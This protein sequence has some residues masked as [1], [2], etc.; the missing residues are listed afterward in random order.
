MH[1]RSKIRERLVDVLNTTAIAVTGPVEASRR[2]PLPR[3]FTRST[4]VQTLDEASKL[5]LEDDEDGDGLERSVRFQIIVTLKEG[6]DPDLALDDVAEAVEAA[7]EDDDELQ[8]LVHSIRLDSTRFDIP[9][10]NG[11]EERPT[12]P[13]IRIGFIYTARYF[14]AA[15]DPARSY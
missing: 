11:D 4:I 7:I 2:I 14:T 9:A 3:D 8:G 12:Q 6:E 10:A 13:V 5:D 15:N 1:H